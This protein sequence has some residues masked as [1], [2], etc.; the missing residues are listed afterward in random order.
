MN[1]N[2]IHINV[3]KQTKK[4]NIKIL[5]VSLQRVQR[6]THKID[7]LK[8]RTARVT[9]SRG[10]GLTIYDL[11]TTAGHVNGLGHLKQW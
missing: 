5:F 10:N 8:Q 11:L 6:N 3:K 2:N 7:N 4:N 9:D 1:I